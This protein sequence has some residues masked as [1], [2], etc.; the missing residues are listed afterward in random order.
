MN[1]VGKFDFSHNGDHAGSNASVDVQDHRHPD[2]APHTI[3]VPDPYLLFSGDYKRSGLDLVLSKDGHDHVVHDYFRGHGRATLAAPDGAYLSGDI[4]NAL[5]GEVQIAQAGGGSGIATVIGRVSKLTGSATAIRNGVSIQLNMG[6]A[7]NKGDVVQAGSNSSLGL[8]FIDGTVFGLSANARMVLNEMVYDPN[9][10]SNSTLL[11]LVQGTITFVAGETAKHGDMKVDTPVATMGIRGTAVLVEIGFNISATDPT[12]GTPISV[13]V[14]FQVL[15]EPDGHVGSYILYNRAGAEVATINQAGQVTSYSVNGLVSVAQAAQIAPEAQAIIQ[16]TLQQYFPSYVPAPLPPSPTPNPQTNSTGGSP[17]AT[18]VP[19][20]SNPGFPQPTTPPPAIPLDTPTTVQITPTGAP[21]GTPPVTVTITRFN[22]SPTIVVAPIVDNN[23]FDIAKQVTIT[24]PDAADIAVPYVVGTGKVVSVSGPSNIPAGLDLSRLV[25][26]D[27]ATGHVSYDPAKFAFLARGESV[28]V[29]VGFDSQSGPDV[30]HETLTVTINGV[31]DAPVVAAALSVGAT[32]GAAPFTANLLAGAIDPDDGETASLAVTN[33]TYKI[34]AGPASAA[35]PAGVTLTGTT[36]SVDPTNAAYTHLALGQSTTIV[37]SYN[38][39]DVHGASVAQT[40]TITITGTNDAPLVAAPLTL[41]AIQGVTAFT[42]DL[43]AGATDPDDGETASLAVTNVHYSIGSG[44][45]SASAPAGISL[46]GTTLSVD[47]TNAA[48]AHLALGQSTTIV[49]SYNVTDV[50]GAS[51]AQTETI[52][53]V[54]TNDAPVVAAPLTLS[55]IEGTTAL[56]TNL[57]TGATDPDDGETASLAVTNVHYLIDNGAASVTAPA[58][59]SL[60]GAALTVDPTNAAFAH[61]A[62]GQSTTIVVSY[63]VTDVHGATVAQTGTITVVGTN[64]APIVAAPLT[65]GATQGTAPFNANLLTGATDPDDGETASLAVTNVHYRI[66]SG[67]ASVTAPAGVSLNGAAL[68]VDPTNAAFAHLALGQ[69]TTIV[70]SYNVTDVHGATV[71]QTG[72]ITVT[73]INDAPI[74]AAPL[75][76]GATQ[77]TAPF[78]AN[79]LTGATDPDDGETASLAVT[80]VHYTV[81]NGVASTVVPAG[82]SLTGT[83]LSVD[84]SNAAFA[85]LTAGQTTAIVVSYD[86]TDVHGASVAQTET[87]TVIGTNS[88]PMVTSPLILGATEGA[89]GVS[90]NLL[91]GATDSDAGETPTLAVTNVHYSIGNGAMSVT[92]PAGVSL[93][94]TT[95]TIDP[96]NAAFV[97]LAASETTSILVS[98]NVTDIH[99]ASVAQTET[100]TITGIN[101]APTLTNGTVATGSVTSFISGTLGNSVTPGA[102]AVLNAGPGLISGLGGAG[103]GYGTLTLMPGDDNSSGAINITSVF[104]ASGVDFFGHNYTSL[105]INNNGN[106]TFNGPSSTFTP[107]TIN[108]GLNNPIIAAFWG[109]VDTRGAGQVYYNLDAVDG[110]MTITWDHVGYYNQHTD[111][112]NSFQIVLVSEGGGNFDIMYRYAQIQWTFGQASNGAPARAGYSAGNGTNYLELPQS[113]N[114]TALLS[115]PTTPGNT[116]V[117]GVDGFQVQNGNVAPSAVTS[118]GVIDFADVD[119]SDVH[120]ATATSTINT[121]GSLTLTLTHDTTGSGT[122]GQFAWT[123]NASATDVQNALIHSAGGT[124]IETFNVTISDGHGGTVEQDVSVTLTASNAN[125]WSGQSSNVDLSNATGWSLGHI[126]TTTEVVYIDTASQ[127]SLQ[128]AGQT[129]T[130]GGLHLVAGAEID[131]TGATTSPAAVTVAGPLVNAGVIAIDQSASFHVTGL[132]ENT[133]TLTVQGGTITI[134]SAVSGHG[135]AMLHGGTI[136]FGNASDANVTFTSGAQD[137]LVL[138]DAT[139][140]TGTISGLTLAASGPF[141][142][143][144]GDTIRLGNITASTVQVQNDAS[145]LQFN[146]SGNIN[147]LVVA[148]YGPSDA[149]NPHTLTATSGND[150]LIGGSG[151]DNFVFQSNM[152]QHVITNF[153]PGQDHI[154]LSAFVATNDIGTWLTDHATTSPT[155][156]ADTLIT[157]ANETIT[158]HNVALDTLQH[159]TTDFIV[160]P[161]PVTMLA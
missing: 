93:S 64:D 131:L 17:P 74:V 110:V 147:A 105:Y 36:L 62:L 80:N 12:T 101:E 153:T 122:G 71:A 142:L 34:G 72:T 158:L 150:V 139:Q 113:G 21:A 97:H 56:T 128:L 140:F 91:T 143:A 94:G 104:G 38:V 63:N 129:E 106:I 37:V 100:I 135:N 51:V 116:G 138:D 11:S 126:P 48:F 61:L 27:P 119:L 144:D 29:T 6:D 108:A 57:L 9:G 2:G 33:V 49:V 4:V 124:A 159:H 145:V 18:P 130:I 39:T 120:T 141:P 73:G 155:N 50:H 19:G 103:S 85:P 95:L 44:T 154:D 16:Q 52:T 89:T 102:A 3:I 117:A 98:Y 136:E 125:V 123:Y 35:V 96:T 79:L 5:T 1:F 160:S 22:T 75:T 132:V 118:N 92:A 13:P 10:S 148:N 84:P 67:A 31:N 47:P 149:S 43:L 8:T 26:V 81:G 127:F 28:L 54:G 111:L 161:I 86:V 70:V 15:Q 82:V 78:N 40:E 114:S 137:T 46:T 87:I 99:G 156:A 41:G 23:S 59:V 65:L 66:D 107:L 152:G 157:I 146:F 134:D 115:L 32:Q 77:G 121:V 88:A 109:D 112:L 76:L 68:T 30:V 7:V 53:V 60:S 14:Q 69:S 133:G 20:T 42:A 25:T 58:G 45:L 55:A 90:A 24:D 151:A 83:T